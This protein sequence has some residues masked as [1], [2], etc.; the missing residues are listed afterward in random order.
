MGD[1]IQ[2]RYAILINGDTES[3][4]IENIETAIRALRSEGDYRIY[5]A[6][7]QAPQETVT[8]YS[9]ADAASL[10]RLISGIPSDDDDQIVI[11]T[12]GHGDPGSEGNGCIRLPDQ[13]LELSAFHNAVDRLP[14]GRRIFVSDN[15][16]GGGALSLFANPRTTL[17]TQGSPGETVSCETFS[18][19]FWSSEAE[20]R[21][22][23]GVLSIQERYAF[24]LRE[25]QTDS[26][27]IFF[28]NANPASLSGRSAPNNPF[29]REVV[30]VHSGEELRNQL[31]NLHAGQL[32]LV[33]FSAD[34]CVPCQA[35]RP[36][37]DSLAR[38]NDGR[39]LMVRA[40]G[41]QGSERD[42]ERYG[43]TTFPTVAFINST[44][45]VIPVQDRERPWESLRDAS[46]GLSEATILDIQEKLTSNQTDL[47]FE[48]LNRLTALGH[49]ITRVLPQIDPLLREDSPF[50][51]RTIEVLSTLG[52]RNLEL[53]DHLLGLL[54]SRTSHAERA[55]RILGAIATRD[56][57]FE[58]WLL[59]NHLM[60][61]ERFQTGIL[62][63][64]G[65]SGPH[66]SREKLRLLLSTAEEDPRFF[67]RMAAVRALRNFE[68]EAP[69]LVPF[70]LRRL[71]REIPEAIPELLGALGAFPIEDRRTEAILARYMNHTSAEIRYAAVSSL[72]QVGGA[73]E[74]AWRRI[75][76]GLR[77]EL[78]RPAWQ[79]FPD[80][81][82]RCH[83]T[84]AIP[85]GTTW[86]PLES[87]F[88]G[89][90][91]YSTRPTFAGNLHPYQHALISMMERS[92]DRIGEIFEMSTD[93]Q[94][95]QALRDALQLALLLVQ[96]P[97]LTEAARNNPE[98]RPWL[99]QHVHQILRSESQNTLLAMNG[100][101]ALC[102]LSPVPEEILEDI[103]HLL[104]HPN[105]NLQ[106]TARTLF[107]RL[108]L[109]IPGR[110]LPWLGD[111]T[112]NRDDALQLVTLVAQTRVTAELF[113]R[114]LEILEHGNVSQRALVI[115]LWSGW[116][117]S[118]RPFLPQILEGFHNPDPS[119]RNRLSR[120]L[121]GLL[122]AIPTLRADVEGQR[123]HSD[124]QI[125]EGL[126]QALL[127]ADD[128]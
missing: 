13:C 5:V 109:A 26:H 97:Y 47:V 40:E 91:P 102:E 120:A 81:S 33:T 63:A 45:Q 32:A 75:L 34:W 70:L 122:G 92:Y 88:F 56:P 103:P 30:N 3:R 113:Q 72:G 89:S 98:F 78:S 16:Y 68:L 20:D 126:N 112:L 2:R 94:Q 110:L 22:R 87:R 73:S 67:V 11:Y 57:E 9:N 79:I 29:P 116:G 43:I 8:A 54:S 127:I 69:R 121:G 53:R 51:E 42:W 108:A 52:L 124:P 96:P 44:G 99:I 118:L 119:A 15:C 64:I 37:F 28:E 82:N 58:T 46:L 4:H 49:Q 24:A 50:F 12:T 19:Y 128:V 23:D 27:T 36:L 48:G 39:F 117:E 61:T 1:G 86:T 101:I 31:Q 115:R 104:R 60:S 93:L 100:L 84:P 7:T 95:P 123:D 114:S 35:Y 74:T 66:R 41:Q 111:A 77:D 107:E 85:F 90:A 21:N 14:Y 71:N 76:G 125:R 80:H 6:S 55:A 38:E 83:N 17:V 62:A 25:G 105:P 59:G 106:T 18:P 10:R 65:Y